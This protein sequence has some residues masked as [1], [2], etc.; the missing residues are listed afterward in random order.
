M[1]ANYFKNHPVIEVSLVLSNNPEAHV[2]NR[3]KK[4]NLPSKVF[5]REEYTIIEN[6]K[7]VKRVRCNT[8]RSRWI[9]MANSL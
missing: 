5:N 6:Y 7:L 9:L 2:L 8:Y 1:I 3:A 4:L